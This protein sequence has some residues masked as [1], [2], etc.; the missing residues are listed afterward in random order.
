ML[1]L[2]W[3]ETFY[4]LFIYYLGNKKNIHVYFDQILNDFEHIYCFHYHM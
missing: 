3:K 4:Q 1:T 2:R